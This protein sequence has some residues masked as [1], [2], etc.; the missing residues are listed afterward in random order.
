MAS[1]YQNTIASASGDSTKHSVPSGIVQA[2]NRIDETATK[3]RASF[4]DIAPRGS[5]RPAVRGLRASKLASTSR[6]KP[7]AAD[8]AVIMQPTI[9]SSRVHDHGVNRVASSAPTS[10]NG[11]ANTEWL[12]RTKPA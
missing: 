9:H 1:E 2:T 5:S 7:I 11:N 6:L 3:A 4:T 8:R 12:K 10:A